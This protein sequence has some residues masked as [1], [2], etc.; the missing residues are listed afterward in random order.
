MKINVLKE[1]IESKKVQDDCIIFLYEDTPFIARQ[2]IDAISTIRGMDVVYIDGVDAL[3]SEAT[4]IWGDDP[5]VTDNTINVWLTDELNKITTDI[6]S[7]KNLIIV[8]KGIADRDSETEYSSFI[9]EIPKLS[10]WQ[11]KDYVYSLGEGADQADLDYIYALYGKD[12]FRLDQEMSK[13]RIFAQNERL[14]L[15]KS[16]IQDGAFV[17]TTT[18]DVFDFSN[19]LVNKDIKA[20]TRLITEMDRLGVNNFGLL[21][22]LI[23]NFRKY[24][25]VRLRSDPT[26]GNT[27]LTDK[28]IYA[29]KKASS[30]LTCSQI[31]SIFSELCDIDK[32]VK[33]GE[34]P[35][36]MMVDYMVVKILTI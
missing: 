20:L 17:D 18:S 11:I 25:T 28:Q 8:T 36:D 14:Y 2:Y 32:K 34:L 24:L 22:I 27:G 26:P 19:A 23:N 7:C 16:M 9:V 21:T 35:A 5:E 1:Q 6:V 30:P 29:I 15:L 4:S 33:T 12:M 10:E 31:V 13:L 3:I